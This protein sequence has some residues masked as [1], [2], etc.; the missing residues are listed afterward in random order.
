M[1]MI[2]GIGVSPGISIGKARVLRPTRVEVTGLLLS[3]EAEENR[4]INRYR[5][6]VKASVAEVR[7]LIAGA[8][9]GEA[10]MFSGEA[11]LVSGEADAASGI[12][13]AG[14][15][16]HDWDL[17][18][19]H[20]EL[21]A[22][23][24]MESDVVGKITRDKKNAHDAL[25]EVTRDTALLFAQMPDEYMRERA[26]DV[27]DAGNRIL[28]HLQKTEPETRLAFEPGTILI[29]E[30]LSP[31]DTILLDTTHIAG[32]ATRAGG[33]TS[34]T[35]I[36]AR[37][38]G[39]PAI[40]GCGEE[41]EVVTDNDLLLI[42]GETG[43]LFINP[44]RDTMKGY[45]VKQQTLTEQSVRFRLLKDQPATTTDGTSV[46]LLAN[47]S[48]EEDMAGVLT[49]GG[50]G[51]GLLRTE[52]LFMKRTS[53]PD[54][55]EQFRFYRKIV[56]KAKGRPVTIRTLDVGGDKPLPYFPLPVE[57]NPFLGYRAIRI[58]LDR[59]DLFR[60]QLR[61]ILRASA[62][63]KVRI[64][65]PMISGVQELR[66]AAVLLEEAKAEL[67]KERISFDQQIETGIMIETPS[68]AM[69][70]DILAK[71]TDFFS[72]GTNDLCQYTLAV[73]RLNPRITDLYDPFHPGVLRLIRYVIEQAHAHHIHVGMCGE[74]ASDPLA[75]L[76]LLG[77]GLDEFSVNAP[78]IPSIKDI[79]T[80]TSASAARSVFLRVMEMDHSGPILSYLQ[81]VTP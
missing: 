58:S 1:D 44:D 35:A 51:V 56:Q 46:R 61:A 7:A 22:D 59:K 4:E 79:I 30:D 55:E 49:Y 31:S 23:P 41:L 14:A 53:F 80:R 67:S 54:E 74:M 57:Q 43:Q 15:A 68:A 8:V 17:L 38:R 37:S 63:G 12:A 65:Y 16:A 32:F 50:E 20:M 73:D 13:A 45:A 18:E 24:Q 36:V 52:L 77:M 39:I 34:H 25:L 72:I 5:E 42:D 6:A 27:R 66:A 2:K 64:L 40:V 47:I 3:G 70:A 69:T 10:G 78:A 29:A 62:L 26:A 33:R 76:L 60:T 48:G 28:K 9:S 81:E 11:D 19:V 71:E 75:T 21:M